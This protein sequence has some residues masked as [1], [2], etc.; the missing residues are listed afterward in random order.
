MK[1]FSPILAVFLIVSACSARYLSPDRDAN[2]VGTN[3]ADTSDD[4]VAVVGT[5]DAAPADI[6]A[7]DIGEPRQPFCDG[8]A[9]LRV[10]AAFVG[11]GPGG[12][13]V[14]T[15]NGYALFAVDGTCTYW[16]AA[17]W[18]VGETFIKDRP[19]RTGKLSDADA[20]LLEESLPLDDI[21]SLAS[22]CSPNGIPD[23]DVRSI[24]AATGAAICS[25]GLAGPAFEAAWTAVK[26]VATKVATEGTP[27][28]GPIHVSALRDSPPKS[29]VSYPWPVGLP[30][31]AFIVDRNDVNKVGVSRLV[32][33]PDDASRLRA[34]RDECLADKAV[35]W[36][37]HPTEGMYMTDQDLIASVV[38]RDAIPYEDAQGLLAF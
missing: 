35:R 17:G 25:Q 31:D 16:V 4:D 37:L 2:V 19:V 36:G 32:D 6:G 24:R 9:H 12:L 18:M 30:L 7:A 14:T 33:A 5:I 22:T 11:G 38:M 29:I 28:D 15:E 3:D 13:R 8:V 34:L 27:V 1:S 20:R 26:T 10:A 21:A 23:A